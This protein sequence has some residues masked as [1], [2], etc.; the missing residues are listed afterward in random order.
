MLKADVLGEGHMAYYNTKFDGY[1]AVVKRTSI[2]AIAGCSGP[3]AWGMV[4]L[5]TP[6]NDLPHVMDHDDAEALA[7]ALAEMLKAAARIARLMDS[8][9]DTP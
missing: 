9:E 8:R 1:R 2:E 3:M 6:D 5:E 4:Y 7:D